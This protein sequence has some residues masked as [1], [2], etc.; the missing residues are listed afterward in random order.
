MIGAG[1]L[2]RPLAF[3]LCVIVI[4]ALLFLTVSPSPVNCSIPIQAQVGS[5]G[6]TIRRI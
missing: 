5:T 1:R 2:R 6:E 3:A 4:R